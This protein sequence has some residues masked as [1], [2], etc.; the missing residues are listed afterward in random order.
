M[1]AT[2]KNIIKLMKKRIKTTRNCRD[3]VTEA[4]YVSLADYQSGE[5]T[6]MLTVLEMLQDEDYFNE[7]WSIYFSEEG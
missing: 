3:L 4:G 1:K 5:L 7:I 6:E 2:K